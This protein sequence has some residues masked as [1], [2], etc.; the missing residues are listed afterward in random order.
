MIAAAREHRHAVVIGGGLLGLE[1]AY[2]LQ[3]RG[4]EVTV[5]H[6]VPT[7]MERQLDDA[8]GGLLAARRSSSAGSSS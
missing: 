1:A 8:A 6:L 7:L 3:K 5:V 4:M 2:G